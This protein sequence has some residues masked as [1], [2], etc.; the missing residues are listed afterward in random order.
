VT[1]G[2]FRAFVEATDY[3]TDL[4]RSGQAAS[5]MDPN[6]AKILDDHL[7]PGTNWRNAHPG[8]TD[9]HPVVLVS[10]NDA[11]AFCRWL[12]RKEGVTYRLPTEAEWEYACRGGTTTQY[13]TGDDPETLS[14]AANVPDASYHAANPNLDYATLRGDDGYVNTAPVGRFRRNSFGL[15]DMHGNVWEWCLDGYD[16]EFY[17]KSA[18]VDPVGPDSDYHVI[19]GGCFM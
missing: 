9:D 6:R 8:V 14:G 1:I 7:S 19:R 2:Q 12:S 3:Q 10:W 5:G 13:W 11:Q 15:Y 4:E 18:K 16:P 17:R